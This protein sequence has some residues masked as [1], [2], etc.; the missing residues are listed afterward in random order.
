MRGFQKM[1]DV[2]LERSFE[3]GL[4]VFRLILSLIGTPTY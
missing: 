1:P 2:S 3:N 4:L